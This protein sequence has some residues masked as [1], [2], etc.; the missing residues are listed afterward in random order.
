MK[1]SA[2]LLLVL[3]ASA[4]ASLGSAQV[5]TN[6]SSHS[7]YIGSSI[8][9]GSGGTLYQ[10]FTN[11]SA[12]QSMT[13]NFFTTSSTTGDSFSATF[14]EWNG[15]T[16]VG[17][18]TVSF[19]NFTVPASGTWT[20]QTVGTF[21]GPTYQQ[22]L[23]LTTLTNPNVNG[24]FGYLTDSSK[25]YAMVLTNLGSG[26][27]VGLGLNTSNPFSFGGSNFGPAD[28]VF[29]QMAVYEGNQTLV[30][31]PETSTVA[32]IAGAVLVAGL[33]IVRTR[34]RRLLALAGAAA[35]AA[36]A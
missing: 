14:G 26:S 21:N 25:T 36:S 5:I 12:V 23:D 3:A 13:F 11:V 8:N 31:I 4:F 22:L 20:N 34:Q 29:S 28:W 2:P 30:P 24:T 9:F 35:P 6:T 10:T 27:T 7:G 1:L 33:V 18:T 16:L 17:G 32:A 19:T 15:S